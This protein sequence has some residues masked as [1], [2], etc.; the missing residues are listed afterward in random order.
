[1]KDA[2]REQDGESWFWKN[3]S[4]KHAEHLIVDLEPAGHKEI[5][6]QPKESIRKC[7]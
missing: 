4:V 3:E 7:L 1:M 5:Y 2:F 6:R